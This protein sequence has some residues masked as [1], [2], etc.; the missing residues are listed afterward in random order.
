M[1]RLGLRERISE[2][3][4]RG[5]DGKNRKTLGERDGLG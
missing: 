2:P 1:E 5:G 3:V 4:G